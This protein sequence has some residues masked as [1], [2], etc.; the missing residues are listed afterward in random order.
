MNADTKSM[1]SDSEFDNFLVKR[2]FGNDGL[3]IKERRN[4]YIYLGGI[5]KTDGK[6]SRF[7]K[8]ADGRTMQQVIDNYL[9]MEV[10][11]FLSFKN[12][13]ENFDVFNM[14]YF[15]HVGPEDMN[16]V[17]KNGLISQFGR[18]GNG[19]NDIKS[20][21]ASLT[22]TFWPVGCELNNL[23]DSVKQYGES[24]T[25]KGNHVFILIE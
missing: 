15:F 2:L 1:L 22:S 17:F 14:D 3:I 8:T 16:D 25:S 10:F 7:I 9:K 23:Y 6:I 13:S 4:D 12:M 20:G 18:T 21:Y 24:T 11:P 19:I 5:D